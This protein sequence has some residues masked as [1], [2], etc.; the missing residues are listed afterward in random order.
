V[1][2]ERSGRGAG[3]LRGRA[4]MT[5][6]ELV[7]G[8]TITGIALAAGYAALSSALDHRQ[9]ATEVTGAVARAAAVRR[10]LVSWLS[11][12][13]L[14]VDEGG[15]EF[16]GIDGLHGGLPDDELSFLTT[17]PTEV[18]PSQTLVRLYVDRDERTPERG[19]VAELGEWRGSAPVRM[20]IDPRAHG[21]ELRYLSSLS[22][23]QHW[24]PSWISASVLPAGLEMVVTAPPADTLP[25][26][27]GLPFLVP[28]GTRP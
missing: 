23:E 2:R 28:L 13:R 3:G 25:P 16:R 14:T 17:T 24:L 19:L 26:L 12:A 20:E 9:R 21:L 6:L 11:G 18:S 7:V 15:P 22:R 1:P 4:G 10:T 5:L 27:L 8:L